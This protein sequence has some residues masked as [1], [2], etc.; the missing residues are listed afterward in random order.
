MTHRFFST[1]IA[2]LFL[3]PTLVFAAELPTDRSYITFDAAKQDAMTP[4]SAIEKLKAGNRRFVEGDAHN[5]DLRAQAESTASGQYPF[6]VVLSCLD[7]R[8]APEIIFDQGVGDLFVARVAGNVINDDMLGSFEF[9]TKVAGSKVI[10]IMGHSACGAVMGACDGVE[11]GHLTGLL[12]KIMPAV[13][14]T[15]VAAD[16]ARNA[17]N[18]KF[19]EAVTEANA[20]MQVADV[21]RRSPILKALVDQGDLLVVPAMHDLSTGEVTFL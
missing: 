2:L 6:A 20:K 17:T 21:L 15:P 8:S 18:R 9:A 10:V 12:D 5:R 1:S 14:A 16:A 3:V 7:S 19:V 4:A 13:D 11:M